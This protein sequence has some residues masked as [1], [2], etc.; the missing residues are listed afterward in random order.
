MCDDFSF[1][2]S[3]EFKTFINRYGMADPTTLR[4]KQFVDLAFDKDLAITQIECRR[5]AHKKIPQ[6]ADKLAYPT[7]VSIEQCTS[8]V[9]AEFHSRLFAGCNCV[10]DLTCGLGIDSF[11]ISREAKSV[12]SV[13]ASEIVASAARRNM[14]ALGRSNVEVVCD[15]AEHYVATLSGDD[16]S[17]VFV[18]PSRRLTNDRTCRTY[19][20][21]DTVPDLLT[22]I[23]QIESK[24]RFMIVKASPMVDISQTVADFSGISEIWVLS[25][26]NEC[27]E[28]LFKIDFPQRQTEPIVHCIN[29]ASSGMV[30]YDYRHKKDAVGIQEERPT[31]GKYLL[32]PNASIMKA[33]AFDDVA[34]HFGISR[35]AAN[36]HLYVSDSVIT[37]YP[38]KTFV[39]DEVLTMSKPDIKRLKS[40]TTSA[41]IACRNFP[42]KPDELR[43]K[44]KIADGGGYYIHAT[45]LAD[46]SKV[47]MLCR[48]VNA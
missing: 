6:L 20:I 47:L 23:P 13:D 15:R 42:L 28:L 8:E 14:Q 30:Q 7:N 46:K 10:V 22:I 34:S 9:L 11:F 39:I 26:K 31:N 32:V 3:A 33:G 4:L 12:V 40:I 21:R 38:G 2:D 5:K 43:K 45:T 35:I 48:L 18:D 29:Y 27:K 1:I 37:S 44:L 17:A 24:C 36:S 16:C 41:N 19:A 25:V